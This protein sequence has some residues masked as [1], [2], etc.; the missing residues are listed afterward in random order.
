[1]GSILETFML[2]CFGFSWPLNVIKA[3]KAKTTK[4]T[5]LPFIILIIAAII[6]ALTGGM[7]GTIVIIAVL[8]MNAILGTV[9]HFKAQKS[10]DS[11]K[12][13]SA[14]NARVIRDGEKQEIAAS[15]LVPG[16][17]LLLEAGDVAAAD[18]R[19]LENYSLQVNESDTLGE[20]N[21]VNAQPREIIV[22]PFNAVRGIHHNGNV[23]FSHFFLLLVQTALFISKNILCPYSIIAHQ[24]TGC[25]RGKKRTGFRCASLAEPIRKSGAATQKAPQRGAFC[26]E[27]SRLRCA[28]P[29]YAEYG[30]LIRMGDGHLISCVKKLT[31]KMYA[32]GQHASVGVLQGTPDIRQLAVAFDFRHTEPL[33]IKVKKQVI[34]CRAQEGGS[35]VSRMGSVA[36]GLVDIGQLHMIMLLGKSVMGTVNDPATVKPTPVHLFQL[37]DPFRICILI[38]FVEAGVS[39]GDAA[40]Y[41]A[42]L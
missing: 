33:F 5:S 37:F 9:Q 6:S 41:K 12:A 10:L 29:I 32:I 4:G 27:K 36:F 39:G 21:A 25:K 34:A 19:I 13:M 31:V 11:L 30:R 22:I 40:V 23:K 28:D 18:G 17:I 35:G 26:V 7:E 3:Y 38:R 24:H 42:P 15:Q 16:D 14:P 8:I 20:K 2:I 1:M